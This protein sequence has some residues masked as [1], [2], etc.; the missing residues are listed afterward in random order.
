VSQKSRVRGSI[1]LLERI[2][3]ILVGNSMRKRSSTKSSTW[4]TSAAAK[5]P[6]KGTRVKA[7][8][9][10]SDFLF[11]RPSFISGV[12]RLVDFGAAFDA[13]NTSNTPDQADARAM[14]SDW[15]SV[16][17]D[18]SAAIREIQEKSPAA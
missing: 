12:A 2:C 15:Y 1:R 14:F 17:D 13:Y 5:K 16:G 8:R 10:N 9:T 7:R 18:I 11:A 4:Y 3:G 6:P